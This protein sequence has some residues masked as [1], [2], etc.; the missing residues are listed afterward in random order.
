MNVSEAG[1][2]HRGRDR[3]ATNDDEPETCQ[4]T[5]RSTALGR[6]APRT[7]REQPHGESRSQV[8]YGPHQRQAVAYERTRGERAATFELS[9]HNK[10]S[11]SDSDAQT[12][13]RQ[14]HQP[15]A[16][17]VGAASRREQGRPRHAASLGTATGHESVP[18]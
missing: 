8:V 5:G 3:S 2:P 16:P 10:Q 18:I 15:R 1:Q 9:R 7:D 6:K 14:D 12:N 13:R 17:G 4:L 11:E